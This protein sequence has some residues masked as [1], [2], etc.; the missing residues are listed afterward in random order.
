MFCDINARSID[1]F[2][3]ENLD[4][5][6]QS[7]DAKRLITMLDKIV[8]LFAD[9]K[10]KKIIGHEAI[11]LVLLVD[12]L[13]DDYTGSWED[14][15]APAFDQFRH[16]LAVATKA[17]RSGAPS[18][19]WLRYGMNARVNSDRADTIQQRHEFFSAKMREAMKPQ[20]KDPKRGYGILD[21]EIIYYRDK[22]ICGKCDVE[23]KWDEAEI[24]HVK[25]HA[26]G[27]TTTIEN[28]ALVHGKC[29]P[30]GDAAEAE[31]A[32]KWE[33]RQRS[34]MGGSQIS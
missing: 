33:R 2:Y 27:G 16:D 20:V 13:L 14:T 34:S 9:Q 6:G 3:Y 29:H 24:H 8:Y 1:D 19:H 12:T 26:K 7:E 28:G 15:L 21:R 11:H 23:V 17:R 18:E 4:F 25:R 22:K 10:R 30:M 31:F 5:N 32:E